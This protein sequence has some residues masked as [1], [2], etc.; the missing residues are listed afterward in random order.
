MTTTRSR[1]GGTGTRRRLTRTV[2]AGGSAMM[3]GGVGLNL[4]GTAPAGADHGETYPH[5]VLYTSNWRVC[6]GGNTNTLGPMAVGWATAIWNNHPELDVV[7]TC[8]NA[9]VG[10]W[11]DYFPD[12]W[13]G[14]TA[15]MDGPNQ[16]RNCNLTFVALNA[17]QNDNAANPWTQWKALGM[18]RVRPRRRA[19]RPC[20]LQ[21]L[22]DGRRVAAH[23][24]HSRPARQ[25]RHLGDLPALSTGSVERVEQIGRAEG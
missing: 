5:G 12:P 14:T 6:A 10:V 18:P 8:D 2:V 16:F 23:R 24:G 17:T 20:G 1:T 4:G 22:H 7:Q 21:H 3:L 9:N 13:F 19:R 25:R 15:C 11:Y